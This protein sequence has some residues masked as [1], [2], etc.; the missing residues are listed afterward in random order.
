VAN[1]LTVTIEPGEAFVDGWLARD[2]STDIDL[3]ANT[4]D[5]TVV[6]GWD[7]DAIYDDE[8]H[9]TRDEADRV[10]VD[11]ASN[12]DPNHP[13]V[14]V[15]EFDTDI[16]GVVGARDVRTIGQAID[17]GTID[18]GTFAVENP[19]RLP[20]TE[21]A[22]GDSIELSVPIANSETLDVYRWGAFDVSDGIAP[23]GLDVELLDGDDTVQASSNTTNQQDV[24][25]P[26]ASYENTSGSESVFKLRVKNR[27]GAAIDNPG[28]D[29]HF[30][31]KVI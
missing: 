9:Q 28:V 1:S 10:I 17:A 29:S 14:E 6:I 7:P 31:Y 8:Q 4:S 19:D 13:V 20:I 23:T 15:W 27:T 18:G 11:L 30:G 3:N 2:L 25:T 21:L 26:V 12:I 24:H 16:D 5:Q 22:D